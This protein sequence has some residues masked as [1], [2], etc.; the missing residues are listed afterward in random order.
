MEKKAILFK[1]NDSVAV[2]L[3]DVEL[4]NSISVSGDRYFEIIAREQIPYGHK[5]AIVDIEIGMKVRKYGEIIG[6]ATSKILK[7]D[8]VHV[9]NLESLR[10]RGDKI[11]S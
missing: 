10:G 11:E 6:V 7:G 4:G 3:D 5:V 2:V 9:K 1:S 8:H